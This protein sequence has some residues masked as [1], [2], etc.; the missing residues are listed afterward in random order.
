MK[1]LLLIGTL[2]LTHPAAYAACLADTCCNAAGHCTCCSFGEGSED[3]MNMELSQPDATTATETCHPLI[4]GE[5]CCHVE[6]SGNKVCEYH[7]F[8][9]P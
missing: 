4:N 9:A 5:V 8:D 3:F 1:T 6:E 2:L 7:D